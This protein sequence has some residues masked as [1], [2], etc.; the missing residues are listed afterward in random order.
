[1]KLIVPDDLAA[2]I[3]KAAD[4]QNTAPEALALHYLRE[5]FMPAPAVA[6]TVSS[7]DVKRLLRESGVDLRMGKQP[8]DAKP[9]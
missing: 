9:G 5:R 7:E 1:M 8:P 3:T 6:P 4:R 2:A